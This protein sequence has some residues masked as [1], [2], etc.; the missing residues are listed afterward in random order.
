MSDNQVKMVD[1]IATAEGYDNL[2]IRKEGDKFQMPE[3]VTG[4]WFQPVNVAGKPVEHTGPTAAEVIK[5]LP[6]LTDEELQNAAIAEDD[7]EGGPRKSV[8]DAI[9]KEEKKRAEAK[10]AELKKAGEQGTG[11]TEGGKTEDL[12]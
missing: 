5:S 2:A 8:L 9:A 1:V 11:G 3:G 4:S 6:G 12:A 10:E 7:R